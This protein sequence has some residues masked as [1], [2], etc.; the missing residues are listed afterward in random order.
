MNPADL[1]GFYEPLLKEIHETAYRQKRKNS[2]AEQRKD[3][4]YGKPPAFQNRYQRLTDL[5]GQSGGEQHQHCRHWRR[6]GS[7]YGTRLPI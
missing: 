7:E 4:V 3:D 1:F 2:I 6:N 5:I